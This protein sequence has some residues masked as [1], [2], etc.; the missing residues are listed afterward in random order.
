M[1]W[2]DAFVLHLFGV[3]I[4]LCEAGIDALKDAGYT[5]FTDIRFDV[6]AGVGVK[7]LKE[8]LSFFHLFA[9]YLAEV[10]HAGDDVG[11][12]K[13]EQIALFDD[14]VLNAKQCAKKWDVAEYRDFG[15]TVGEF[16]ADQATD[17]DGLS[18]FGE[19]NS[20]DLAF[21]GGGSEFGVLGGEFG[22]FLFKV[23]ADV[24]TCVDL[25][26]EFEG[27]GDVLALDVSD[28]R[29]TRDATCKGGSCDEWDVLADLEGG[30]FVGG[31]EDV[32]GRDHIDIA[33]ALEGAQE[34]AKGRE[35][36]RAIAKESGS[37]G[38]LSAL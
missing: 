13:D 32:G 10:V 9:K 18:V 12:H 21:C 7:P 31:G 23:D 3:G 17:D 27:E 1:G 22:E 20:F 25:G 35:A 16:V 33:V 24:G 28:S 34:D 26:F 2:G 8:L 4:G 14:A 29:D 30:F 38:N 15:D 11:G 19:D 6:C 36:D 5:V 37:S